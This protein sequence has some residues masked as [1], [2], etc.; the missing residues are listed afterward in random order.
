MEH[1]LADRLDTPLLRS[2]AAAGALVLLVLFCCLCCFTALYEEL[3]AAYDEWITSRYESMLRE[4]PIYISLQEQ[5]LKEQALKEVAR[6]VVKKGGNATPGIKGVAAKAAALVKLKVRNAD[7]NVASAVASACSTAVGTPVAS[8]RA[9]LL[10]LGDALSHELDPNVSSARNSA[11]G[12]PMA[13]VRDAG[14][15]AGRE[16]ATPPPPPPPPSG[17]DAAGSSWL[18]GLFSW[19]VGR[20][21][22][23][24]VTPHA[25]P[26]QGGHGG[27]PN[28]TAAVSSI[29]R[30]SAAGG[31]RRTA[32]PAR[33][34]LRLRGEPGR[35]RSPGCRSSDS[36]SVLF[37]IRIRR[38]T[39]RAVDFRVP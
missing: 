6:K 35:R 24:R 25:I 32:A 29:Y 27:Q 10:A 18:G 39:C 30:S 2:A 34:G 4:D 38:D 37:G 7:E 14:E 21:P 31:G 28:P 17:G 16:P 8:D 5:A 33:V 3:R 15:S 23:P 11:K 12:T 13:S 22:S 26:W 1:A 19:Q 20:R 9:P 36:S